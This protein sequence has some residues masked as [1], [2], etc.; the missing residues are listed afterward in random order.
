M[1]RNNIGPPLIEYVMFSLLIGLETYLPFPSALSIYSRESIPRRALPLSRPNQLY[2]YACE[3]S[4]KGFILVKKSLHIFD[5]NATHTSCVRSSF[6]PNC[7]KFWRFFAH[8]RAAAAAGMPLSV[9]QS[10]ARPL[11]PPP[12]LKNPLICTCHR[13]GGGGRAWKKR[14]RKVD[15]AVPG[16]LN[17][18]KNERR[19]IPLIRSMNA[20]R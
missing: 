16:L 15:T 14:P 2:F 17:W 20:E 19:S 3:G 10:G 11:P 18:I 1:I 8:F 7:S 13:G 9:E 5:A 4:Q 12:P 6:A